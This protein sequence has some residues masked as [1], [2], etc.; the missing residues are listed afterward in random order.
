[1]NNKSRQNEYQPDVVSA[2][3]ETLLEILEM[4]GLTQAQLAER[5][6]RPKK[7]INEIIKGKAAI[8]PETALQLE[9][10]LGVPASF[11]NQRE[12][13]YRDSLARQAEHA[14]LAGQAKW[15]KQ[16]PLKEMVKHGWIEPHNDPVELLRRML[17]F[18]GIAS[19]TLWPGIP[20]AEVA[21]R[22]AQTSEGDPYAISVWLRQGE[23]VAQQIDCQPY[24]SDRFVQALQ[25][26][27]A[28]THAQPA[29]ADFIPQVTAACARAGVAVAFV[30]E[31]PKAR[32]SGAAR[33]L[34]STKAA[35]MLSFRYKTDDQLWFSFFH[36]AGHILKHHKRAFFTDHE[37]TA[38][39]D[40][41]AEANTFAADF[42][43]PPADFKRLQPRTAH[44]SEDEVCRFADQLGIAPSIV[45]G[46]L[47]KEG[48]LPHSHM[49]GL[50]RRLDWPT[51]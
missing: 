28:L 43:I 11:W 3:G 29:P 8:T 6:G 4:R 22:R 15:V 46:R 41:E 17:S 48:R 2:P 39:D 10:V 30:P 13:H 45:V 23:L 19:P 1:M 38:S 42:L 26:V 51:D 40:V 24:D 16:F 49:N 18:F 27:R 12:Q 44:F 36:E 21:F 20:E 37:D 5:T 9:R 31:L 47:Q 32:I 14:S 35:I 25:H 50:K 34:S 7:T 33:W